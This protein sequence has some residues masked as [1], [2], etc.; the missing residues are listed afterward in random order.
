MPKILKIGAKGM[1][2]LIIVVILLQGILGAPAANA[3]TPTYYRIRNLWNNKYLFESGNQVKYGDLSTDGKAMQWEIISIDEKNSLIRNRESGEYINIENNLGYLECS[4]IADTLAS[5][6][7][8][9][10]EA[11]Y[12]QFCIGS[13]KNSKMY[14]HIENTKG[15]AE[16]G[17]IFPDWASAKW[18]LEKVVNYNTLPTTINIADTTAT[19]TLTGERGATT[20]WVTYE[21]E[22]GTKGSGATLLKGSIAIGTPSGEASGRKAVMLNAKGEY[23][24]WKVS[25]P[26]NALVL[27]LSIPDAPGGGGKD[28]SVSIYKNGKHLQDLKVTSKY[29]W[30][31]GNEAKPTNNPKNS[32]PRRIYD[33]SQTLLKGDF[34]K[35][36][37]IRIQKDSGDRAT[38]YNIDFIE[39]EIAVPTQRPEA[40]LSITE[41]GAI[42]TDTKDDTVAIEKCIV[43]AKEQGKIVWIPKG[44][45]YQSHRIKAEKVTIKGSGVWYSTLYGHTSSNS[46]EGTG[47][48]VTGDNTKFY[49]FMVK[50]EATIRGTGGNGFSGIFGIGSELHNI[51]VEHTNCGTW[52]GVDH[53]ENMG[54]N[55]LFEGC[56]FR[57]TFADGINLC[58][59]TQNS[60][61]SNCN[62]RNTGDDGIAIWSEG[63]YTFRSSYNNIIE[64]CTVQLPW[65]AAGIAIYGGNS[66]IVQNN[67]ITDTMTYPGLTISSGFSAKAF[68]GTTIIRNN[69][70]IRCGG[71]FWNGQQYGAIWIQ[72]CDSDID[73]DISFTGNDIYDA[74]YSAVS[75]QCEGKKNIGGTITFDDLD[76]KGTG[77]YGIY[78]RAN[79]RGTIKISNIR[80]S[81]I[82]KTPAL[83]NASNSTFKVNKSSGNTGW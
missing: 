73:G 54:T 42:G 66:N 35:G 3:D 33:E 10:E 2:I 48:E 70:I 44:T 56:R 34:V 55:L 51:W 67:N 16:Y 22:S 81:K 43:A 49:D 59:G 75:I 68:S 39:L 46:M 78:I 30:L 29:A 17:I 79:S 50:G 28:Y 25:K 36:D 47:F 82:G 74:S 7:W 41:Y 63:Q 65:R 37:I 69:D 4:D 20:P 9:L 19:K 5:T 72:A 23:V 80:M 21:A 14:F 13:A 71:T 27:R 76:I 77:T 12:G 1:A 40:S 62:T 57:N 83:L 24:E 8:K 31:Y 32:T 26:A 61:I 45:F 15:Y 18:I 38:Y 6:K 11:K 58:N 53:S 64:N 52:E 60:I